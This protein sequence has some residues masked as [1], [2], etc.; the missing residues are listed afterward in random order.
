M[1]HWCPIGVRKSLPA[2]TAVA[3]GALPFALSAFYGSYVALATDHYEAYV[4]PPAFQLAGCHVVPPSLDA[5][6]PA[7]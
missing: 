2:P 1:L 7:T 6:T 5:S 4:L 3:A